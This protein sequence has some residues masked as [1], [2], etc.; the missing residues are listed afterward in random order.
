MAP[1][2][3]RAVYVYE[4]LITGSGGGGRKALICIIC[5]LLWYT[6]SYPE[7]LQ[8]TNLELLTTEL[9]SDGQTSPPAHRCS[10]GL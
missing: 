9:G 1:I 4:G 8:P 10:H 6:Y 3:L 7:L 2:F 5:Q